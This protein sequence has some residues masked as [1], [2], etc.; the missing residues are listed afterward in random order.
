[1]TLWLWMGLLALSALLA[2]L[3]LV[4]PWG[5]VFMCVYVCF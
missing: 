4:V 1:M 3:A 2:A 5:L